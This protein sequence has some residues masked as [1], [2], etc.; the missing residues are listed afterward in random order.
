[1]LL[2][3]EAAFRARVIAV[4]LIVIAGGLGLASL[5]RGQVARYTGIHMA[6]I[7]GAALLLTLAAAAR[8]R[9]S[10]RPLPA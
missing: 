4:V 3:S 10:P 1:M 8:V 7:C 9:T 6:F 5:I 2:E